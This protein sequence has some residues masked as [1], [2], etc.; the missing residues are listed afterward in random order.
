VNTMK[1]SSV[2]AAPH[3]G[4]RRIASALLFLFALAAAA[5]AQNLA[6][7]FARP[8]NQAAYGEI[9][10]EASILAEAIEA[11]SL[12]DS[13]IAARLEEAAKKRISAT[14]LLATLKEDVTRY[15]VASDA[16]RLRGLL[17][18]NEKQATL[19]VEQTTL[20][21]RAG[22]GRKELGAALDAAVAKLGPKASAVSRTIA[23]LSV[24]AN[25]RAEYNLGE[26]TRLLLAIVLVESDLAD[27]RL[28]SGLASI[29]S[30]VAKGNSVSLALSSAIEDVLKKN[31][32]DKAKATERGYGEEKSTGGESGT[33]GESGA[34][35]NKIVG[36]VNL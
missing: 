12:S 33:Q 9:A 7:W 25:A 16:L 10:D 32:K 35:S 24:V 21:L 5:E 18:K 30:G 3:M 20:L 17:P 36:R 14:V 15:L 19:M 2:S 29:R 31:L 11:A 1:N 23:A 8:A 4:A 26:D 34:R 6:A 27:S 28:D 13:L 22:I